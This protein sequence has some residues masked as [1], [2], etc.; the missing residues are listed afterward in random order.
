MPD[1]IGSLT[2]LREL[3]LRNNGL[4]TL[5]V[6][7]GQLQSLRQLDL[8]GNPLDNLP[9]SLFDLPRLEKLDLR[10]VTTLSM[11][12]D[13]ERLEAR[14]CLVYAPAARSGRG[15]EMIQTPPGPV[16]NRLPFESSYNPSGIPAGPSWG[17]V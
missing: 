6:S 4:T 17:T 7:I 2:H 12:E 3:H 10:W 1:C 13:L 9:A 16:P 5:P 8:R 11:S 15:L 14:G